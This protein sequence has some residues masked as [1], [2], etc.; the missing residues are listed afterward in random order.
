M[1]LDRNNPVVQSAL[2]ALRTKT[3]FIALEQHY[4]ERDEAALTQRR[5]QLFDKEVEQ[6]EVV[7]ALEALGV[8]QSESSAVISETLNEWHAERA[9]QAARREQRRVEQQARIEAESAG[10]RVRRGV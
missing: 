3:R 7:A 2:E 9:E 1:T 5:D 8:P 6:R 4:I 10:R